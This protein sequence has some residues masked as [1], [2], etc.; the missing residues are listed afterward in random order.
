M[1]FINRNAPILVFL[2]VV[3]LSGCT[4]YPVIKS[5]PEN[6]DAP[7]QKSSPEAVEVYSGPTL[8][9]KEYYSVGTVYVKEKINFM[10]AV[11][12]EEDMRP[13]LQQ[14][15]ADIDADAVIGTH[16][17]N[18]F[19]VPI[20]ELFADGK[21]QKRACGVAV[22]YGVHQP[23]TNEKHVDF[24]QVGFPE[25]QD[26]YALIF[27]KAGDEARWIIQYYL[28]ENGYYVNLSKET[29]SYETLNNSDPRF[30]QMTAA[31]NGALPVVMYS[32]VSIEKNKD[33]TAISKLNMILFSK[34]KNQIIFK[35]SVELGRSHPM[36]GAGSGVMSVFVGWFADELY[37]SNVLV[38]S[39]YALVKPLLPKEKAHQHA[40][41]E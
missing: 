38:P 35:N 5:F 29:I 23:D 19:N 8:P 4:F 31:S 36:A 27:K 41:S 10:Y 16:Y 37:D 12:S 1:I 6:V 30:K 17:T 24:L 22:K 15:A 40:Y 7:K 11:V 32:W 34:V 3:N 2:F 9:Q 28:E 18:Q 20:S 26:K 25:T 14:A 39:S 33:G 13:L 21:Y